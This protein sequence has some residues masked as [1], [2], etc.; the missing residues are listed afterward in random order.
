MF[1]NLFF[2]S[3]YVIAITSLSIWSTDTYKDHISPNFTA[4]EEEGF[5]PSN[6]TGRSP[7]PQNVYHPF[8]VLYKIYRS[9]FWLGIGLDTVHLAVA[10]NSAQTDD[11]VSKEI[12]QAG[13]YE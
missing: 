11:H 8:S 5:Y 12:Y 1:I 4:E 6:F 10:R 9:S 13:D 2:Y 3:I 7:S